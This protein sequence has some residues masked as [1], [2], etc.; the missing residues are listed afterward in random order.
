MAIGIVRDPIFQKHDNGAYHPESPVRLAVADK[1]LESWSGRAQLAP[2]D[3]RDASH[4]EIARVHSMEHVERVASTDGQGGFFDADTSASAMSYKAALKANGGLMNLV[5]AALS[6]Q[7]RHGLALVR[8]PGHHAS[9]GRAMGFCL[10][11]NVAVAA[12]HL[13]EEKGL[14]RILIVDWDVHHGNG[15]EAIFY[16]D[17]RVL[18]FS[19]HQTPF[20]PGTGPVGAVGKGRGRG[21]NL[22]VPMPPGQDS[23]VYIRVFMDLLAPVARQFKPQFILVSAGFDA[24]AEDPLGS[25]QISGLGYGALAKLLVE[26]ADDYCPGCVVLTLEGGYSPEAQARSLLKCLDAMCGGDESCNLIARA[27]KATGGRALMNAMEIAGNF[28]QLT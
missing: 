22:N 24:H 12:A 3:L 2:I 18:Y 16:E 7:V 1:Y 26:L 28:W 10:Y 20:Y 25:M 23:L 19:A 15:T 11:N 17:P 14:E 6:G 4:A 5:D 27:E 21:Y 8:P 13:I 9:K